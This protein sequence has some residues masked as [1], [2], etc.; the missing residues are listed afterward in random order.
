MIRGSILVV[1]AVYSIIFLKKSLYKH[2]WLG[3]VVTSLGI[4]IVGFV[5]VIYSSPSAKNPALG[6]ILLLIS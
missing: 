1:V 3:V 4:I 5:S 6:V 2:Q